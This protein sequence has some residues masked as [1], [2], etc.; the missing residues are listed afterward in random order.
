MSLIEKLKAGTRNVKTIKF[1]GTEDDITLQ[2]LS[3]ADYQDAV[4]AAERRFKGEEMPVAS[5]TL[6][7][8]TD[9]RTTQ[10][11][12][13]A[14]RD[15]DNNKKPFTASADELRKLLT[16]E[17]K[18]YLVSEYDAFEDECSPRFETLTDEKFNEL[19]DEVKKKPT[20]LNILSSGMQK[21]L[22]QFL[23]SRQ[24]IS[25]TPSGSTS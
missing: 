24:S 21:R 25:Q 9:E 22:L 20:A 2:I 8:Y 23:A 4:F 10:I 16:K 3:N 13:R 15:P 19:W 14:L 17:Q 5:S 6:D 11:L 12:F 1:P 7:A 18:E